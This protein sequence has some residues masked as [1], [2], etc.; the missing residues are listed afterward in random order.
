MFVVF[1]SFIALGERVPAMFGMGLAAAVLIDAFII[2]V[3]LLP[4]VSSSSGPATWWFPHWL[5]RM[6]PALAVEPHEDAERRPPWPLWI[7]LFWATIVAMLIAGSMVWIVLADDEDE[8]PKVEKVLAERGTVLAK[9]TANGKIV[10]PGELAVNFPN[11]GGGQ[12][13]VSVEVEMGDQVQKGDVLAIIEDA[14]ARAQLRAAKAELSGADVGR[15]SGSAQRAQSN[16]SVKAARR[17][18]D[19]SK[20]V[21]RT[22]DRG[23]DTAVKLAKDAEKQAKKALKQAKQGKKKACSGPQ[24]APEAQA[25]CAAAGEQ[26]KLAKQGVSQAEAGVKGAK[27]ERE[28]ARAQQDSAV[29]AAKSGVKSAR[30][31]DRLTDASTSGSGPPIS[32]A[33]IAVQNARRNLNR[34]KLRAP[35]AGQ[36]RLRGRAQQRVRGPSAAGSRPSGGDAADAASAAGAAPPAGS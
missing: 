33:E 27:R 4:A 7:K 26:V 20:D 34:T 25:A 30:K 10:D 17:A 35:A 18:L 11:G 29:V 32:A 28:S 12:R 9:Y 2:R 23:L 15:K 8:D 24:Q 19:S 31:A 3:L 22:T 14:D 36:D 16:S 21:T 5:D 6:L 13:I 1:S